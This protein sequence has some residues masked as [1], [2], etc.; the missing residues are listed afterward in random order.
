MEVSFDV[1]WFRLQGVEESFFDDRR[2]RESRFGFSVSSPASAETVWRELHGAHPLSWCSSLREC[3]WEAGSPCGVGSRRTV[4][5]APGVSVCERYFLWEEHSDRLEN[6]FAVEACT[7]PGLRRFGERYR[8][9]P[10][11]SGSRLD[12]DFLIEPRLPRPLQ[13]LARPV[14]QVTID[15]LARDTTTHLGQ[16]RDGGVR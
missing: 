3:R 7:V 8:V 12:W 11:A 6:A 2:W 16:V 10:T 13:K 15:R 9:V 1:R 14:T 4:T 5:V